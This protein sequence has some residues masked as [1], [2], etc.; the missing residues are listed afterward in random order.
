MKTIA[1]AAL[2]TCMVSLA[3]AKDVSLYK[4]EDC[5]KYTVQMDLNTCA[6]NNYQSADAALNA[7]YKQIMISTMDRASKD[8]LRDSERIW[9]KSRDRQCNEVAA[10]DE[11]GS[12][13]N[14]DLANCLEER[15]AK[16]IREL[17]KM[18][19]AR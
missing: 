10:P 1:T 16:R 5:G 19:P 17:K 15:T 18:L 2:L 13:Y 3:L 11:G 7:I 14:M 12:I 4:T 6:G 9:I 8:K